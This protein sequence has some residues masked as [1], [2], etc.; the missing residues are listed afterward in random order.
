MTTL[1]SWLPEGFT[2]TQ[3]QQGNTLWRGTIAQVPLLLHTA[4]I[5]KAQREGGWNQVEHKPREVQSLVPSGSCYYVTLDKSSSATSLQEAI[6]KLHGCRIG[7]DTC[8]GRGLITCGLWNE[9]EF[10]VK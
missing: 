9:N 6:N 8:L 10:A 3:D 1:P 5:G 2:K 4:I 7:A